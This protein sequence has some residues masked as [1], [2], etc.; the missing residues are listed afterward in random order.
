MLDAGRSDTTAYI[1]S[2]V[3]IFPSKLVMD[4]SANFAITIQAAGHPEANRNPRP[5]LPTPVPSP[6]GEKPKKSDVPVQPEPP[7]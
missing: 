5:E 4:G 7:K 2:E 1:S 3:R 6:A